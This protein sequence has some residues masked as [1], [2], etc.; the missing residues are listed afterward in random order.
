M[1]YVKKE[2]LCTLG[3]M[4]DSIYKVLCTFEESDN[5]MPLYY[6]DTVISEIRSANELFFDGDLIQ[7]VIQLNTLKQ[8]ENH[9]HK[10][11]KK[12][13]LDCANNLC[14]TRDVILNG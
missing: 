8:S 9:N 3:A 14:R 12:V 7:I 2:K 5:V 13:I 10:R 4:I 1:D 11:V 6:L